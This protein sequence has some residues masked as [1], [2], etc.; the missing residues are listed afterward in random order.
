VNFLV[1]NQLPEASDLEIWRYAASHQMIVVSKDEDFFHLA[2]AR[3]GGSLDLDSPRQ[4]SNRSFTRGHR[5]GV[6][7][8]PS[9]PRDAGDRVVEVR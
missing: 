1:D 9:V 7:A 2:A 6:A 3:L 5:R 4:L 8:H